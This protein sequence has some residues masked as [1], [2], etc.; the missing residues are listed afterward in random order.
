MALAVQFIRIL[1]FSLFSNMAASGIGVW[2]GDAGT[3][4]IHIDSAVNAIVGVA[5]FLGS[6]GWWWFANKRDA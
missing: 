2:D 5:G 3:F 4:S 1:L 6:L